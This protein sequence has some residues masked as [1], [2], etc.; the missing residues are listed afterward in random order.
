MEEE[1]Q[2]EGLNTH[3]LLNHTLKIKLKPQETFENSWKMRGRKIG[4]EGGIKNTG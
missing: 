3:W 2:E 4:K 1:D